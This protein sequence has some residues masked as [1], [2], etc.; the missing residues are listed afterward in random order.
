M[1]GRDTRALP[2]AGK[3]ACWAVPGGRHRWDRV[4]VEGRGPCP[5]Q[6]WPRRG[7]LTVPAG[8]EEAAEGTG[9]PGEREAPGRRRLHKDAARGTRGARGEGAA[10]ARRAHKG[11]G[12]GAQ[13]SQ[14][15]RAPS[16]PAAGRPGRVR[17]ARPRSGPGSALGVGVRAPAGSLSGLDCSRGRVALV[18]GSRRCSLEPARCGAALP[19]AAPAPRGCASAPA[20]ALR[21]GRAG[22]GLPAPGRRGG[23]GPGTPT[24]PRARAATCGPARS[25]A[26]AQARCG[27]HAPAPGGTPAPKAI[28]NNLRGCWPRRTPRVPRRGTDSPPH[29]AQQTHRTSEPCAGAEGAS[30]KG[31]PGGRV[32]PPPQEEAGHAPSPPRRPI[33]H[34]P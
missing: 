14:G 3:G 30:W 27:C 11:G 15:E 4:G 19:R 28:S 32:S 10:V 20:P 24:W 12:R 29:W 1:G 25:P 5:A 18:A 7:L 8:P 6:P 21:A 22:P 2:S 13:H 9:R 16:M 23:A 33:P 34:P 17:R 26:N 31:K